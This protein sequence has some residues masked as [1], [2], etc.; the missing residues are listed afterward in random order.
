MHYRTKYGVPTP[1]VALLSTL[2][3]F[4]LGSCYRARVAALGGGGGGAA[5]TVSGTAVFV[6]LDRDGIASPGDVIRVPFNRPV[7][8]SGNTV[9]FELHGGEFGTLAFARVAD[10]PRVVE[11]FLG[12]G[13]N[14]KTRQVFDPESTDAHPASGIAVSANAQGLLVDAEDKTD[15]AIGQVLDI[16]PG[17]AAAPVVGAGGTLRVVDAD[18]DRDGDVD[19]VRSLPEGGFE[20]LLR[21]GDS[22]FHSAFLGAQDLAIADL[23]LGDVD[24]DG[25]LDLALATDGGAAVM[26]GAEEGAFLPWHAGLGSEGAAAVGLAD[27]DRNGSLDLCAAG[28]AGLEVWLGTGDGGLVAAEGEAGEAVLALALA[29]FDRDGI[30]DAWLG[31]E[32]EDRVV[33]GRGDGGFD[34]GPAL[35]PDTTRS[36]ALGDVDR[37]GDLDA[38]TAHPGSNRLWLGDGTGDFEAQDVGLSTGET[39]EVALVDV[40]ADGR[41]DLIELDAAQLLIR[42]RAAVGLWGEPYQAIESVGTPSFLPCDGDRDG[43]LDLLLG[44][45][46]GG[47]PVFSGSLRGTFGGDLPPG[48]RRHRHPAHPRVGS[49]RPRSRRR[50]RSPAGDER[51]ARPPARPRT[52]ILRRGRG[53]R[54]HRGRARRLR[55]PR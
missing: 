18:L 31:R 7:A 20:V 55:R 42:V 15:V 22:D 34:S 17:F 53:H 16:A 44:S 19:L 8:L 21:D 41:L 4:G 3:L 2:L 23:V 24:G 29:D 52:R 1:P 6:D 35:A 12:S 14:L 32:G 36:I 38:V 25:R 49:L 33:F 10:D 5:T 28:P 51:A 26:R 39:L 47:I 40:D 50:L 11:V 30:V 37:D 46:D 54:R 13:A 48:R 43:D 27:L 9:P 45:V